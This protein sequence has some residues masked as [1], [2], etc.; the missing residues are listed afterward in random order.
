MQKLELFLDDT[1]KGFGHSAG[2]ARGLQLLVDEENLTQEGMGIGTVALKVGGVT[3][4]SQKYRDDPTDGNKY[5]RTYSLDTALWIGIKGLP[6]FQLTRIREA[7]VGFYKE[8]PKFQGFQLA[9]GRKMRRLFQVK[10]VFRKTEPT[11]E[12]RILYEIHKNENTNEVQIA[13]TISSFKEVNGKICLMNEMGADWFT[14][15]RKQ[16]KTIGAPT[17][18]EDLTYDKISTGE[19]DQTSKKQEVYPSLYAPTYDLFFDIQ[20]IVVS[21][22]LPYKVYWGREKTKELCW[23]GFTIEI[24][25]MQNQ[26]F[27]ENVRC[28]YKIVFT[29][30]KA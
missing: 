4:F 13:A 9:A 3:L 16:D 11:G 24:N 7:M 12:A 2:L 6:L 23:A 20:D 28:T 14:E 25:A 5:V 17:A 18:W 21:H 10:R 22:K 29:K 8:H 30:G 27:P 26:P 1:Y 19:A 15:A